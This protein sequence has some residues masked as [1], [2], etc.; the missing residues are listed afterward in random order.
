MKKLLPIFFLFEFIFLNNCS[1]NE[2]IEIVKVQEDQIENQMISSYQD[3]MAAASI[4]NS[5]SNAAIPS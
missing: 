2:K 3:G 1:K 4:Y 5:F